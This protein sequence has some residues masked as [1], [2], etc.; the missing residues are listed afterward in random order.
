MNG[1]AQAERRFQNDAGFEKVLAYRL[2]R[3]Y[4]SLVGPTSPATEDE[5]SHPHRID[6]KDF[7]AALRF[8]LA[9]A[10]TVTIVSPKSGQRYTYR[11]EAKDPSDPSQP[12]FVKLLVG[13]SNTDD[14][15]YLGYMRDATDVLRW[16][17]KSCRDAS[18]PSFLALAWVLRRLNTGGDLRGVEIW[19][20]GACGRCGR[21]RT[22][23][24]SIET[25]LGPVCAGKAA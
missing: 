1:L 12:Y 24:S 18:A 17:R 20:E 14:F 8:M 7:S 6:T 25:G 21:K 3:R 9:G 4:G 15:V 5:M 22:V 23:P 2:Q 13:A 16:S 10:A 19:H 11:I